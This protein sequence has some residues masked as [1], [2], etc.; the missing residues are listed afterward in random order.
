MT[1]VLQNGDLLPLQ[2]SLNNT[3]EALTRDGSADEGVGGTILQK[4]SYD[5]G[6][7]GRFR[8]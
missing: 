5:S 1:E 4:F 7:S 2:N 8:Q 3:G 6:A